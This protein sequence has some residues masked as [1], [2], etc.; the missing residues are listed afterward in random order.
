[1]RRHRGAGDRTDRLPLRGPGRVSFVV[2]DPTVGM[3]TTRLP[4]NIGPYRVLRPIAR[5]GMAEVYEV[6]DPSSGEHLAL[7]LLVQ[8]GGAL[9]RFNREY[10]AMIRLNHPHIVRVY[11]YGLHGRMPWLTMEL[12]DGTPIQAYAKRCGRAGSEQRTTETIRLAHD[13]A[14]ALDHI[15]VNGLVH[16]DLKSANVLVLP[17]GRV[18]L[19]DFGTARVAD[20]W[21][22]ITREGEFIGTF[23]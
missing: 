6:S 1:L 17:D 12:V 20:A 8:T 3:T 18:K 4:E 11:H 19:I 23:A 9:A 21:E 2:P 7:K 5:G 15:H 14:L 22:E 16:R 10:E 13:L